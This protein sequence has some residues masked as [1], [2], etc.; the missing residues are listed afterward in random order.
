[1]HSPEL[2]ERLRAAIVAAG[3]GETVRFEATPP[4]PDGR[5]A[6]VDFSLKPVANE[7]GEVTMLIPEGWESPT[8]RRRRSTGVCSKANSHSPRKWKRSVSSQAEWPTIS[9]TC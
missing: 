5:L 7:H 2:Q 3:A 4:R 9:I 6:H 1:V 8:G